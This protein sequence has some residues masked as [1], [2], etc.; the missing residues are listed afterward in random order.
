[1]HELSL[2]QSLIEIIEDNAR[3]NDFSKVRSVTLEIGLLGHVEPESMLFC[4]DAISR[5]TIAEGA[6][7]VIERMQGA[8][9]CSVCEKTVALTERYAAC[10]DCG[11]YQV[12][13]TAGDELR[14]RDMEVE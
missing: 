4:F 3:T 6:R 11:G 10:P 5:G 1:M 8:G 2:C 12:R 14:V 7:L 9:W 13:M